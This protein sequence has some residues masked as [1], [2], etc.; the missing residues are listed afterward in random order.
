MEELLS[1]K[2]NVPPHK[3]YFH[4]TF[5]DGLS[6]FYSDVAPILKEKGVHATVFLNSKFID[7]KEM[8]YR[9]KASLLFEKLADDSILK[10]TYKNRALLDELA[11]K[12]GID[13]DDYLT[14]NKPYLS[15][16]QINEL[17][18]EG[19]TFGAHSKNHPLYNELSFDEQI[20]QT[21]ESVDFVTKTFNLDYRVFSFPFTDDGV[22]KA[23][24][25][26]ASKFTDITFGSAGLK[27]DSASHN[28]QRLGMELDQ[29]GEQGIKAEYA[30]YLMKKKTGKHKIIRR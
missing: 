27:E 13:F 4:L 2:T 30:Y 1:F 9:F 25:D 14:I 8:F 28:L 16:N 29:N 11:K 3:K 18:E 15:S 21:K 23:F 12:H 19:F 5:D 20:A 22:S 7:N 26:E 10:V 17:V 24:F 6:E